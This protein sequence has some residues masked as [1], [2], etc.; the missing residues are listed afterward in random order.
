LHEAGL[1]TPENLCGSGRASRPWSP[2]SAAATTAAATTAAANAAAANAAAATTTLIRGHPGLETRFVR[3]RL[4]AEGLQ[5][6]LLGRGEQRKDLLC[7]SIELAVSFPKL[8]RTFVPA[9][10][11]GLALRLFVPA[12]VLKQFLFHRSDA[13]KNVSDLLALFLAQIQLR[14]HL[15]VPDDLDN[16]TSF[17]SADIAPAATND[18]GAASAGYTGSRRRESRL[19]LCRETDGDCEDQ[20]ENRLFVHRFHMSPIQ[21]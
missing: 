7:G 15:G 21:F 19:R 18:A 1:S 11:P 17:A 2:E 9:R 14:L 10:P 13:E 4:S 12:K 16:A 6:L 3:C 8:R 20:H 5:L